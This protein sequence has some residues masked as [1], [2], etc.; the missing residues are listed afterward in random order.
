VT[1]TILF[2]FVRLV[3][4]VDQGTATY[5]GDLDKLGELVG[6]LDAFDPAFPIVMP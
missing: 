4:A 2:G 5:E 3:D 1:S 6:Y